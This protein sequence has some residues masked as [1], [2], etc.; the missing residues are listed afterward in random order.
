[1]SMQAPST[2]SS[3]PSHGVRLR[4][5]LAAVGALAALAVFAIP[6]QASQPIEF[7]KISSDQTEAGAH[8]NISTEFTLPGPEGGQ[9]E[10]V[11]KTIEA[12]WPTGVFGNPQAV[13]R[14]ANIDFA[15]N[16]CPSFSQV[17]WIGVVG[18]SGSEPN[19]V[20]GA[21]PVYDME[22]SGDEETARFAF[23]VPEVNIPINIP[24]KV[25]TGSDYGLT[26]GVTGITQQLPLR[27]AD[28]TIWG[29]PAEGEN[30]NIRFPKGAPGEPPGCPGQLVPNPEGC[31]DLSNPIHSGILVKPL[32]DNPTLC[33]GSELPVQLIVHSY[34]D[35][36]PSTATGL[37]PETTG[38]ATEVFRPVFDVGLTTAE[39]DAPSGLNLRLIAKQVLGHTNS[40]SQLRSA[41]VTLPVGLSVNPDAADGQSACS[42]AD[43]EFG[44]ELPSHCPDNSKIGTVEVHTPALNG[45]LK[46]ALYIGEPKPGNQYRLFMLFDG[47]GIHAKLAPNIVPDPKTGQLTVSLTDLPQVP[48]EEFDLH[49]FSSDRGLIATPTRCTIYGTEGEFIPWNDQDSPQT[50][51]PNF[52]IRSGPNGSECPGTTRPFHPN[53]AAGTTTPVAG[54]FSSFILKLDR[55]DGDQFL[56]DL[57]FT[58]PPGLTADL[59]GITYC[60]DAAIA[61]AAQSLGR[62]QLTAPSCP[63]SSAI[64]T[65]NVAAGPGGHPFHAVG[66]MYLA[67]PFKGAPLSVVAVTPALA[68]PYDYG[69]VVV[70]VAINVDKDDAHVVAVSDTVPSII[71]GI[72][73]R[74]RSIQ[75]NIDRSKFMINPTNCNP[76]SVESQGI[77][78][79]GTVADF[80][81]PFSAVNCRALAF[82]PKMTVRQLGGAKST[83]RS[84]D[85]SLRFDLTTRPGDANIKSLA[86]TLS[87]AFE[88]DQR[89][90]GNLCSKAELESKRCAGRQPIGFAKTTTPLLEKPLE[91]PA[92]AV[93]GFG[94]LPHVVFILNGQVSLLPQSQSKT[95]NGGEL[96]TEVP[97]VPDAPVGHFRLTLL[98]GNKGYI[99]NTRSLC[100]RPTYTTVEYTGQNGKSYSQRVKTKAACGKGG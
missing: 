59:R 35:P 78:D 62:A 51:T 41:S 97:V 67:G 53:L 1:M 22:P 49:L 10:E 52:A 82:K 37:Y 27:Q 74:M 66:K 4:A 26:V 99:S 24:I 48:F 94:G 69:T 21:A 5:A 96:R 45:P 89:H 54:A 76:F 81:S 55:E 86:V 20:F 92:Y 73:I 72:P 25:R 8:P 28:L 19:H 75:V 17:G 80:S 71:G 95:V 61:A 79:E 6:A 42:D 44:T 46:G 100:A 14:C 36:T 57:N 32:I 12:R 91:G 65:S 93:S 2:R 98:G 30:D 11:A 77:G 58:M 16:E 31:A 56:G 23:T 9:P 39:A 29:Y 85:P 83:R 43:A 13:P 50:L 33:T 68:G 34:K 40:P 88:I 84:A 60:P 47:F 64:G 38:C 90:L 87:K 15:L 63:A 18:K 70:R 3:R 7:F